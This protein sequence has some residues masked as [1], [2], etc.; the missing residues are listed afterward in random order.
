VRGPLGP[1]LRARSIGASLGGRRLFAGLDLDVH[2]GEVVALT[3]VNGSGK[4]TLLRI[5]LGLR[6]PDEGSVER[7]T[8]LTVGYVP[9]LDPADTGL[10]FPA[11]SVVEQGR[12]SRAM[13]LAA[14]ARVGFLAP[15]RRRYGS[16]SGGERR[17]VLLARA[18]APGPRL[19]A[20][21]EPTA[22]VD[23]DGTLEFLRLVE[24]EVRERGAA[25]VWV[26]HGLAAVEGAADR[27]VRLGGEP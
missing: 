5:L 8:D 13:S 15:P 19:L 26:C 10:P 6:R 25:A 3:G 17:R 20:L 1:L 9:Q 4:T 7:A 18:I 16:L 24:A 11:L 2:P 22:G 23:A 27:I 12:G 21:D 14:L